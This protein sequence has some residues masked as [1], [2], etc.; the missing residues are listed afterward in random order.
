[1]TD[2]A[3]QNQESAVGEE[4]TS[5]AAPAE[6]G[7][8]AVA[9][10]SVEAPDVDEAAPG[11]DEKTTPEQAAGEVTA[12]GES[13]EN[14]AQSNESSEEKPAPIV[15]SSKKS[16]P[17][18]KFDPD[19][20]TLRFLFANRDGL[21]VTVACAPTDTV[22][23]VKG[24]L[25]SVWPEDLPNCSG[26][27]RLRLV[28]MGKGMLMPDSRTLIDC[29]VPVFKTHPTP[30]NVSVKPDFKQE[31][32]TKKGSSASGLSSSAADGSQQASQ[33]CACVIL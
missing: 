22:G 30:V 8:A 27:D 11:K 29:Q 16:R 3:D 26:G 1:M 9:E 21:T 23:E 15:S 6:A 25:L 13:D 5:T 33:G 12:G 19:K 20:I 31:E 14:A 18:Y 2:T 4:G 28:C 24:A 10:G 32:L 7:T 17:P